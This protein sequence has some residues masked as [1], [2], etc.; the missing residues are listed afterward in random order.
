MPCIFYTA[1][2]LGVHIQTNVHTLTFPAV[3]KKIV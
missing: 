3:D 1:I 2:E